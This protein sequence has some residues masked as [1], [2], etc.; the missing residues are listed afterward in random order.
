M[1]C[2]DITNQVD[3]NLSD[4]LGS[5][6]WDKCLKSCGVCDGSTVTKADT[7]TLARFSGDPLEDFGV[8]L[9]MNRDSSDASKPGKSGKGDTGE[10]IDDIVERLESIEDVF[11]LLMGNIVQEDR[12]TNCKPPMR[13]GYKACLPSV[14]SDPSQSMTYLK[15]TCRGDA[16]D[17]STCTIELPARVISC[18]QVIPFLGQY[19]KEWNESHEKEY[20][21]EGCFESR[22][23]NTMQ[24]VM[25]TVGTEIFAPSDVGQWTD[26]SLPDP[27]AN[28]SSI[29]GR[30]PGRDKSDGC[31]KLGLKRVTANFDAKSIP[32]SIIKQLTT[33]SK[34]DTARV[35]EC[36]NICRWTKGASKDDKIMGRTVRPAETYMAIH[37]GDQCYCADKWDDQ[38][39]SKDSTC[40][41][42]GLACASGKSTPCDKTK[43]IFSLKKKEY[44]P[45]D[46]ALC[47][48][49]MLYDK[50]T[51]P[52]PT[53]GK[54][55]YKNHYTLGDV[56]PIACK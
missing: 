31:Y 53:L 32:T 47:D 46:K 29:M 24:K 27:D 8:V 43:S 22:K 41:V 6:G 3:C 33:Q 28:L 15:K 4:V 17:T 14:Q 12:P 37:Y 21:F 1:K 35:Q 42:D 20:K 2:S 44:N 34:T 23:V 51:N 19:S 5:N 38:V 9:N 11:D 54:D 48:Q 55:K 49:F 18:P 40:G 56:C 26:L 10:G 7:N 52:S 25:E 30:C 45:D 13:A 50:L 36:A 16:T 39:A